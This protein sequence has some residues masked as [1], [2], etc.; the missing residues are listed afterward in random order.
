MR[1]RLNLTGD[2]Y[3]RLT[4]IRLQSSSGRR[5]I[6]K[7]RCDCGQTKSVNSV[8]LR[9]GTT[10]SC[11]C[12]WRENGVLSGHKRVTHGATIG[13]K[14]TTEYISWASMV[15]RCTNKNNKDWGYYGG[16]GIKVCHRWRTSFPTFLSDMGQKPSSELT[17]ERLN[18]NG[19][20]KPSNCCW[21][22]RQTQA[23]NKRAYA[24]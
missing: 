10:K 22:T 2:K 15:N 16:R 11:G 21:A 13:A 6:W 9:R 24:T 14:R 1:P 4:V 19:N 17:I 8:G 20:Y 7:C 3:G 12:L 23:E 18:N 5:S